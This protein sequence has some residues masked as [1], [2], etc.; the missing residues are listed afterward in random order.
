VS[1]ESCFGVGWLML[2]MKAGVVRYNTVC[3]VFVD[4]GNEDEDNH[5]VLLCW[6]QLEV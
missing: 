5:S 2:H 6:K 4:G 3:V 1:K